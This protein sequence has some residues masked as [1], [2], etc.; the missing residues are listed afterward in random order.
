L[1]V[2]RATVTERPPLPPIDCRVFVTG[3]KHHGFRGTVKR[4]DQRRVYVELD[5]WPGEEFKFYYHNLIVGAW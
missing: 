3:T 2:A 5:E 1:L 4:H